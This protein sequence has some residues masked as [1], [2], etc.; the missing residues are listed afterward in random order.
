[1]NRDKVDKT[2]AVIHAVSRVV[3]AISSNLLIVFLVLKLAHVVS[4]SWFWVLAPLWGGPALFIVFALFCI[5][6]AVIFN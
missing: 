3:G 4:W 2:K 1:M 6:M 5:V